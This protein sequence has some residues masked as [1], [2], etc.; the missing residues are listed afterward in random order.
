VNPN[1]AFK[2]FISEDV[3]KNLI[4]DPSKLSQ[5]LLNLI[6]NAI[7]FVK[8]GSINLRIDVA[9]KS[10][11]KVVLNFS[12]ADT[13]I[14]IAEDKLITIFD[15]YKQATED[16]QKHYGGTGLGLSIVKHI[17][18]SL[19]GQ[20]SVESKEGEGT[21]FNFSLPYQVGQ[22]KDLVSNVLVDEEV[23][24]QEKHIK[25]LNILV[26][27][28]NTMNQKLIQNRLDNWGCSNFITD[29]L[30]EGIAILEQYKIDVI[31]MDLRMPITSG[32]TVAKVIRKHKNERIKNLPI[33]ALT[34][35]FSIKDKNLCA[36]NGIN[37]YLLK[38]FDAKV[39]LKKITTNTNKLNRIEHMKSPQVISK[40]NLMEPCNV[41]LSGVIEDCLGDV[42]MIEELVRLF[43]QNIV[44]FIGKTKLDLKDSNAQGVQFNTHK[45]KAGLKIMKTDGLL[46]I[47]EQMNKVCL[48]DQ[49]FKYLNFLFDCF[50]KEY[51]LIENEIEVTLKGYKKSN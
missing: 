24:K 49:D 1:V 25:N 18:E 32:Y 4:G 5:V 50:V 33:I 7:K 16:T 46:R 12:I 47:V 10:K 38:P 15:Y 19:E 26:F 29:D 48:E 6:G 14:G 28:D 45:I 22:A 37:D 27:E 31:L 17:V 30:N 20:I 44:E 40:I 35:D 13:G 36:A 3:P 42:E 8:S 2:V 21:T 51:P 34:A 23:L 9:Q 41:N 43:K 11:N 39:L